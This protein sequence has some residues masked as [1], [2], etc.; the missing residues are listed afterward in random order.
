[1]KKIS[2]LLIT[3]CLLLPC[4]MAR[5][6]DYTIYVD[7]DE[8]SREANSYYKVSSASF[9][10]F[11]SQ[12]SI[13]Q[14]SFTAKYDDMPDA[15]FDVFKLPI[16]Y[17][18]NRESNIQ[19]FIK[20]TYGYSRLTHKYYLESPFIEDF[21]KQEKLKT[22]T[23]SIG[24]TTGIRWKYKDGFFIEPSIGTSYSHIHRKITSN[25][26]IY[27]EI[28][29]SYPSLF[30][31]IFDTTVELYSITPTLKHQMEYPFGIGNIGFDVHLIYQYT[32]SFR[33]KSSYADFSSHSRM[34]YAMLNYEMPTPWSIFEK[35]LSVEPFIARTYFF[36]DIKE[37]MEMNY[38]DEYG[39]NFIVDVGDIKNLFSRISIGGSYMKGRDFYGWKIGMTFI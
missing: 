7:I 25:T 38:L 3:F 31:D 29:E 36:G 13:A 17:Y 18:F 33:S 11:T 30:S 32:S 23:H 2:V 4:L 34:M 16:P 6:E 12:T 26:R 21:G 27:Q 8:L 1:M 9:A 19:P 15:H 24:L 35:P 5:A 22:Q 10:A 14:G 28:L 39:L 37:G 20:L